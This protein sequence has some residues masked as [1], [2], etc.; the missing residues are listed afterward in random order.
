[1]TV[2]AL[3]RIDVKWSSLALLKLSLMVLVKAVTLSRMDSTH[4]AGNSSSDDFHGSLKLPKPVYSLICQLSKLPQ[5][6]GNNLLGKGFLQPVTSLGLKANGV[7]PDVFNID[8][9]IHG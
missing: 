8:G 6:V 5:H 7:G 4:F 1:M 2:A 3:S 9:G